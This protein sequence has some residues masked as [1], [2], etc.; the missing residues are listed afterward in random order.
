VYDSA[1]FTKLTL[2][3][4]PSENGGPDLFEIDK[5]PNQNIWVASLNFAYLYA[6]LNRA[7]ISVAS[8]LTEQ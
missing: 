3:D 4:I 2:G 7:A 5:L 6:T 8:G 1:A